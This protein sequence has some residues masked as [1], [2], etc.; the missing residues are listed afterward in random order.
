MK[1]LNASISFDFICRSAVSAVLAAPVAATVAASGIGAFPAGDRQLFAPGG[2]MLVELL[3][4]SLGLWPALGASSVLTLAVLAVALVL[5]RALLLTALGENG[6][7]AEPVRA[8]LGRACTHVPGLLALTG[9]AFLAQA[10]AWGL[11]LF[12]AGMARSGTSLHVGR[13]D[14]AAFLI[15]LLGGAVALGLGMVR[16]LGSAALVLGTRDARSAFRVGFRCLRSAPGRTLG[17]WLGPAVLGGALVGAAALA[18]G[19]LDVSRAGV[20]RLVAVTLLHQGVALALCA[21]RAAWLG[22][23]V[24]VVSSTRLRSRADTP[25]RSAEPGDPTPDPA[26]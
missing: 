12:G 15:V 8:F 23:A 7:E 17:R 11:S 21:C 19:A 10:L 25:A 3:R 1:R 16:D 26:A 6:R 2:L 18:V 14:L 4:T 5:P 13:A 20:W 24:A 22:G 9:V